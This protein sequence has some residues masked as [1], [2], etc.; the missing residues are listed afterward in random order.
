MCSRSGVSGVCAS[1]AIVSLATGGLSSLCPIESGFSVI[2]RFFDS[3]APWLIGASLICAVLTI[4]F[5]R[6]ILGVGIAVA[7]LASG[8]ALQKSYL[9]LTVAPMPGLTPDVR[10]LFFNA[11]WDNAANSD[12]IV[13]ALIEAAPDIIAIAEGSAVA[14]SMDRL[15]AAYDFVSPCTI[16]KCELLIATNFDV[17]RF[18]QLALD[19]WTERFAV[20]EFEMPGAGPVHLV[21]SHL[22]KPWATEVARPA[23]AQIAAQYNWLKGP[24]VAVGDFNM[25]PWSHPMRALMADTG[26]RGVRGQPASWPALLGR[27]GLPIDQILLREG[28]RAIRVTPFGDD[29]NSNHRGFIA[30]LAVVPMAD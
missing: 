2:A 26:F 6:Q 10:V 15:R 23:L 29:L 5:G 3:V 14:P 12:R 21:A 28:I 13:T 1:V 22:N 27:F 4:T 17:V 25:A 7:A 24:V 8:L 18:W 30:E 9:D 16:K 20:L 19:P 11:R